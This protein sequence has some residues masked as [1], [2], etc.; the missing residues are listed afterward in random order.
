MNRMKLALA[1][2]AALGAVATGGAVQ[3]QS[4][5]QSAPQQAPG[6]SASSADFSDQEVKQFATAAVSIQ[7]IQKDTAASA[8][9]KQTKMAGAVQSSGLSPEKFNQIAVASRSDTTLMQRIQ[10]AATG[11]P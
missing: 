2:T 4:A 6:A 3:A 1:G 7:N 11:N 10:S 5:P 9:E 8:E